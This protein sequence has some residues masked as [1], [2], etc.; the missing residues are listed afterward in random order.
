MVTW[1][2]LPGAIPH[3]GARYVDEAVG[4]AVGWWVNL[5][6][7]DGLFMH[8]FWKNAVSSCSRK[9]VRSSKF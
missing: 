2:P 6:S 4:F 1:L 8:V 7:F 3:I 9:H 5:M